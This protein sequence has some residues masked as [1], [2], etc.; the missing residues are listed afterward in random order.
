MYVLLLALLFFS[1]CGQRPLETASIDPEFLENFGI[2]PES[3]PADAN[4]LTQS[5]VDLGRM[6][7]YDERL[8]L[9]QNISCNTCHLLDRYGVDGQPTS[10]GHK[11]QKGGRNAPTVY[12]AA[13]HKRQFWDGRAELVEDQAK[14]PVLNPIEMAMP[15]AATVEKRL[16]SIPG[17]VAAF[18]KAFPDDKQPVT[19]DNMARA[20]A[21]FERKLT[22][23]SRWDKYLN[24]DKSALTPQEQAGFLAFYK[25]GCVVCH[26]GPYVGGRVFMKAG[27]IKPWPSTS[28]LGRFEVTKKDADRMVFK[29]PSLRNVAKTGPYFHDGSVATLDVA[30]RMMAEH[31]LERPLTDTEIGNIV[32]WLNSLTSDL[33]VEFI[34]KPALPN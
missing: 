2:A 15:D 1:S 20:I 31:Q 23:P 17:Y 21:A 13:G 5:K 10:T 3:V 14:G 27:H 34:R 18:Q 16:R 8:S 33:P 24:G 6:L 9:D 25:G 12:F 30:V 29:A 26:S 28:D 19:F 11:Q 22:P 7:Y 32:A 4:A